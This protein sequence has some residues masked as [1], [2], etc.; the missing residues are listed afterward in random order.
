M[1]RWLIA[2][3]IAALLTGT[4]CLSFAEDEKAESSVE[5]TQR[6]EKK[7]EKKEEKSD[8]SMEASEK[9]EVKSEEVVES[10]KAASE[11]ETE[12]DTGGNSGNDNGSGNDGNNDD[13]ADKTGGDGGDDGDTGDDGDDTGDDGDDA[14]DDTG[15]DAGDDTGDDG[16]DTG[17]DGDDG[18]D[19]GDDTGDVDPDPSE[20]PEDEG[21]EQKKRITRIQRW[22]IV[23]KYLPEGYLTGEYDDATAEA[24]ALFQKDNNLSITG[25]C[26]DDTY[27]LLKR[28]AEATSETDPTPTPTPEVTPE[29]SPSPSTSPGFKKSGG[30]SYKS[31]SGSGSS[32]GA[33]ASATKQPW[34]N[35]VTPGTAL[36]SSH[37]KGSKDTTAY[38]TVD[39]KRDDLGIVL[40][41]GDYTRS[42]DG[43]TLTLT[44][45]TSADG[46]RFDGAALRTLSKSGVERLTLVAGGE[47]VTL[48]TAETL[49][50]DVYDALRSA[51]CT[52]NTFSYFVESGN[53]QMHCAAGTFSAIPD[54]AGGYELT[55]D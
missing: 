46:W 47:T 7:E 27:A 8:D 18:D 50:G 30:S 45:E 6:E 26:D 3:M 5:E 15:D 17:D 31:S 40:S 51:G 10:V 9:V 32:G 36:T 43:D 13:H 23:L 24:V 11:R 20:E 34:L 4:L 35:G 55:A 49:S 19:D 25:E 21:T 44:G 28:L 14:G 39:V 2:L 48:Q 37:V 1:K 38:G 52:D 53:I 22:L 12:E 33:T 42:L 41:D 16:D 29:P 54:E